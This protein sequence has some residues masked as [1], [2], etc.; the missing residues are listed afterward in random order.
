MI[1]KQSLSAYLILSVLPVLSVLPEKGLGTGV[2][3]DF[4]VP[5]SHSE[6]GFK[7]CQ[8]NLKGF[9]TRYQRWPLSDSELLAVFGCLNSPK[10]TGPGQ[11]ANWQIFPDC[12]ETT[13][14]PSNANFPSK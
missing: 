9:K 5:C 4:S 2:T 11:E 6:F 12:L 1:I 14:F 3:D 8:A 7:Q 10:K 13:L